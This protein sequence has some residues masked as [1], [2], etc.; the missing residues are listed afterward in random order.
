MAGAQEMGSL[1][2]WPGW[3]HNLHSDLSSIGGRKRANSGS[4][5][6]AVTPLS[7]SVCLRN[8]IPQT[9][10]DSSFKDGEGVHKALM[11]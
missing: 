9:F 11:W 8:Y 10:S 4:L 6:E 1:P 2:L 5:T 7:W 3:V